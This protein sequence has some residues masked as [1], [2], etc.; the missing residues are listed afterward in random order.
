MSE[1][2]KKDT[3]FWLVLAACLVACIGS[4]TAFWLC[5]VRPKIVAGQAIVWGDHSVGGMAATAS[6][7]VEMAKHKVNSASFF[8]ELR[9][10]CKEDRE[11]VGRWKPSDVRL[12][13]CEIVGGDVNLRYEFPGYSVRYFSLSDFAVHH[14]GVH[15]ED[16]PSDL[17]E[18]GE[19]PQLQKEAERRNGRIASK[20][21]WLVQ[22]QIRKAGQEAG[23]EER[24]P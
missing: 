22:D 10:S 23:R 9:K 13:L 15:L 2:P 3:R 11:L 20:I 19:Y 18:W 12:R 7:V 16:V 5:Y 17:R 24:A 1:E 14:D 6:R 21:G 8:A 4:V